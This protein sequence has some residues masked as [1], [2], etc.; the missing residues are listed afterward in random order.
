M[1]L[2]YLFYFQ[3]VFALLPGLG[4]IFAPAAMWSFW[5]T[6]SQGAVMDLAGRNTGVFLL[7]TSLV[8]FFAAR[9]E[10]SSLRRNIC[11]SYFV[12]H[13]AGFI[14]YVLPLLMG[15]PTFGPAWVFSLILAIVFGYFRF[16]KPS[17]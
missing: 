17:A 11:L 8:A 4:F 1:R 7:V 6:P 2:K 3:A 13:A 5:G 16:L 15:G 10:D 9:T 12:L 14:I